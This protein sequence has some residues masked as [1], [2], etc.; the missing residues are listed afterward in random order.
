MNKSL[1]EKLVK[2]Q[3][4]LQVEKTKHNEFG[5]FM[6]RSAEDILK[7]LKPYLSE[8]QVA[9]LLN[10]EVKSINE[11][12]YVEATA[13]LTDGEDCITTKASAREPDQP[14]AKMDSSQTT[15]STSS[16]ARKYALS[17][18]LGLD[19]GIDSDG[20]NKKTDKPTNLITKAQIDELK[21]LGFSDE[22]LKKMAEYYKVKN[23]EEISFEQAKEAINKQRKQNAKNGG[24]NEK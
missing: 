13:T 8:L 10:D 1:V 19:D 11:K 21:K 14:K 3:T 17:G 16:Y 24:K 9:I 7:A 18:L 2:I 20:I 12:Y 6:F 5:D 23:I 22:R 15:G 4:Q